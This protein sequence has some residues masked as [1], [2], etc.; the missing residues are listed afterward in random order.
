MYTI[1][2][3]LGGTNIAVGLCDENLKIVDKASVPTG[4]DRDGELIVKDM[5][6]LAKKLIEKNG[7]TLSDIEY[8][9]IATPGSTNVK[10]GIVEYANNLPFRDF[11]IADIFKKFLPVNKVL[12]ANDAN[13]A[14][15]A[16]ALAGAAKG[17]ST[18]VMITLGT[19]VGGGV[20]IDGKIF[21]GGIND[22]GTELGHI[23]IEK[24]GRQCSCGRRGCWETYSSA[25]GLAL[26]TKEKMKELE[27]QEIPSLLFE[28]AEKE[29]KISA[30]TAFNAMKRGDK[31]GAKIVD[32][33]IEY[34]ATGIT[35]M[36]NIF[37]PEVLSIGGGVCN[38]KEYLTKPLIE[39][40]N[41]EQ[42]TRGNAVK[43]K[44]VIAELGNDAGI[45]GAAGL[46]K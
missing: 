21:T 33:Y 9:G 34:L 7:L 12:I 35:D 36:I 8:V 24:G 17:A 27:L 45:I 43:T 28:E 13:A 44:I 4:A 29:G 16:E 37:Q 39:L 18:S 20:I 31:Y 32:E 10:K 46:G 19:G 2:V 3:D 26:T 40:V 14:A 42:Y 23:V 6:E 5:A 41:K 25:T 38:E 15:L 22:S 11:H 30:R 1:G